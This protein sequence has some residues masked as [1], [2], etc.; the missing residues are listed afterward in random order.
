MEYPLLRP[1]D[2]FPVEH[3]GQKLICLRDPLHMTEQTLFI[4]Y[5][6]FFIMTLFDG[7]HSILDI[8]TE[9]TR[10]FGDLL[11]RHQVEE[12]IQQLD[13]HYLLDNER[14]QEQ[15]RQVELTFL[16]APVRE[17]AHAGASYPARREELEAQ[18]EAF[19]KEERGPGKKPIFPNGEKVRGI[20][21][22]HIDLRRGG[23]CSAWAYKAIEEAAEADLFIIFGTGHAFSRGFF[24]LTRKDFATPLGIVQTDREFVEMLAAS[25]SEDLFQDEFNHKQEHSIEF[26]V[27]FLNH[28]FQKKK[29]PISIVPILCGS[30][31]EMIGQGSSPRATPQ[32][33]EFIAVLKDTVVKQGKKVCY[34]AGVDLAHVGQK[35]G[36]QGPL[37]YSLLEG[38]ESKDRAMLQYVQKVDAEGFFSYVQQEQD[39]RR[40]CGLSSIYIMLSV[41]EAREGK[42]LRYEQAVERETQSTVSY[43]SLAFI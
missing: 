29:E 19:F 28:I 33:E 35:F 24:T 14:F 37:T 7:K 26:Q 40:I 16:Q 43:A 15:R 30:F 11:F 10:T 1:V 27:V 38:I 9:Y 2:L 32:V 20:V 22:P 25:Y 5:P 42:L 39:C 12:I 31:H 6:V 41:M 36:D 17:A 13:A 23:P 34:I 21:A 4:P 3:E 8:Q 18:L